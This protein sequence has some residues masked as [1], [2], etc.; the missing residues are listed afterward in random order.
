MRTPTIILFIL[1]ILCSLPL[2]AKAGQAERPGAGCSGGGEEA[3]RFYQ[4]G[5]DYSKGMRGKPKDLLK[6]IDAYSMAIKLGNPKAA[7]NLGTMIRSEDLWDSDLQSERYERMNK[8]FL[9]AIDMGCPE[10]Y[11]QL[12]Y[13]Y[14]VGLGVD[15]SL[16]QY[17]ELLELGIKKD[18]AGCMASL[19]AYKR[20]NGDMEGAK[21]LLQQALDAGYGTAIVELQKIYQEQG[22]VEGLLA[23]LRQAGKLGNIHSLTELANI[24]RE[25]RLQP[26]DVA[27][28]QC[29][30][31]IAKSINP[32]VAADPVDLDSLCPSKPSAR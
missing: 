27:Y 17:E 14:R 31:R 26:K 16:S 11:N 19:G 24:Y 29:F 10:G 8:F 7:I 1:F 18:S 30:E 20:S 22:D 23:A 32:G 9:T 13:S 12:A 28:A 2:V 21:Q 25:G 3:E 15:V 5:L 4:E 6:A